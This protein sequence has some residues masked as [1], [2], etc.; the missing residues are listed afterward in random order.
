[1][2]NI[3][4]KTEINEYIRDKEGNITKIVNIL[5]LFKDVELYL[6]EDGFQYS[7]N[8]IIKHSRNIKDIIGIGDYIV[9]HSKNIIDLIEE[10][11]YVNGHLIVNEIYGEDDNELYF[12][13]E[14]DLNKSRYIGEKD[15][16][17]ISTKEKYKEKIYVINREE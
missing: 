15:I 11:D 5:S 7:D 14:D 16:E 6:G 8:C 9:K 13:I 2:E 4:D 12:E 1:M 3:K 10:G 17:Y